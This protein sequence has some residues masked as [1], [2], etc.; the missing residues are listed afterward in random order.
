MRWS[1]MS[2]RSV[3][4]TVLLLLAAGP[5]AGQERRFSTEGTAGFHVPD[6]SGV[7]DRRR[8]GWEAGLRTTYLLNDQWR[9]FSHY[10][11]AR[12]NNTR[13]T[14]EHPERVFSGIEEHRLLAG[15]EYVLSEHFAIALG[16][17]AVARRRIV[18]D[19]DDDPPASNY[20]DG[21]GGDTDWKWH[22]G[23][24]PAIAWR[25]D[26]MTLRLSNLMR[27]D[28]LSEWNVSFGMGIRFW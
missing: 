21:N 14:G 23:F 17:G 3:C 1:S 26:D 27:A 2:W 13:V 12:A 11:Y 20:P 22:L 9:V 10:G 18:T 5:A 8:L 4:V 25:T 24:Q 28:R 16:A 19:T 15:P 6:A 7:N